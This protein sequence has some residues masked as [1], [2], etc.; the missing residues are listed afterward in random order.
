MRCIH[1]KT[2]Y[3]LLFIFIFDFLFIE[4]IYASTIYVSS[5]Y[6][7]D[8]NDGVE[9][10]LP[11]A[12]VTDAIKTNADTILL[13]AGDVFYESVNVYDKVISRYG[14]GHN[15][16][17]CGFRRV[18]QP[19]W[20]RIAENVWKISLL[21]DN[22]TGFPISGSSISN[23]ICCLYE[24][25]KDRVHGKK[26]RYQKELTSDWDFWQTERIMDATAEDYDNL[27]LYYSKNPNDLK[28]EF[29]VYN[30]GITCNNCII[31]GIN[32]I[33][34]GFGISAKERTIIRNCKI[35]VIGG[36]MVDE[37]WRYTCYG[38]GIEFYVSRDIFDCVVE[39]CYISR[40]YDCGITIQASEQGQATPRNITVRNNMIYQCCEGW[41][42]F[43]RNDENV[44][45]D[46]CVFEEN[47][48]LQSGDSGFGYTDG[49]VKY[50]HILGNNYKGDRGMVIQNN[51]FIDGNFFCGSPYN[52]YYRSNIWKNNTCY[53]QRG[54]YI[55][56]DYSGTKDVLVLPKNGKVNDVITEY[57]M[58]TGDESTRFIIKKEKVLKKRVISIRRKF[59]KERNY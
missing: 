28:L 53:I 58:L 25:D 38:N 20:D 49:R 5:S 19:K 56:S 42:D 48:V 43:L 23:N 52:N 10:I 36:R 27:Y 22:Y 59:L 39:D 9:S 40:C 50:C 15:P 26:V 46:N 45:F 3:T 51:L 13:Y 32:L 11:K 7:N 34:F 44:L 31:D 18:I 33:G 2:N 24:F 41:E 30:I 14:R 8:M 54:K 1:L 55:L 57:R 21:D 16:T 17:I 6:G 29:S 47:M 4:H 35:D 37:G 12:T